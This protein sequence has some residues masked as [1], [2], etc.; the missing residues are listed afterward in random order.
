MT[1]ALTNS[2]VVQRAL[3][4]PVRLV[5]LAFLAVISIGTL[6]L[7]LPIAH[8]GGRASVVAAAFTAVS[9]T[10]VTGLTAVDTATYWTTFGHAIIILLTQVGGYGIM[11]AATLLAFIVR[12]KMDL[13]GSLVAQTEKQTSGLADVSSILVRI[14]LAMGITEGIVWVLLTVRFLMR[15]VAPVE[16]IWHGLFYA[17]CAFT[18]AG[19][20]LTKDSLMGY[21]VDPFLMWPI[22]FAIFVGSLGYPV[23]FELRKSWRRPG[24]WSVHTRITFWG[25]L[26][27]AVVGFLTFIAFEW[28]NPHTLGPMSIG[29]KITAATAGAVMP[30]SAGFNVVDY[31]LIQDES[32]VVTIILMFI[33]GGSAGTSGGLKV[34]TFF[35]LAYVVLAEARGEP[36]VAIAHRSVGSATQRRAVAVAMLATGLVTSGTI[37]LVAMTDLPLVAVLFDVVSAFGTVGLSLGV[38]PELP[39][40]GQIILM[41]LMFVGRVGTVT[42]ASALALRTR[43]RHYALPEETPIVG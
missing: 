41:V 4:R 32:V 1:Q 10:C 13:S 12:G 18:N 34:S 3:M 15:G 26:A 40:A 6:L 21:V 14:G 42:A 8:P 31:G 23:I 35:L 29:T 39:A 38:T 27:L 30:R 9:A 37:V 16:A 33:G 2:R 19:F 36:Q 43:R 5:P 17:C 7:L 22:F 20:T 28:T 11:S 25:W 24:K